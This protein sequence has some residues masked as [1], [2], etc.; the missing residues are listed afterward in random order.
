MS[1]PTKAWMNNYNALVDNYEKTASIN[2]DG[3]LIRIAAQQR[4]RYRS[5]D[6]SEQQVKLLSDIPGWQ[7][8]PGNF[9]SVTLANYRQWVR[10]NKGQHPPKGHDLRQW[11]DSQRER[12]RQ[13]DLAELRVRQFDDSEGGAGDHDGRPSMSTSCRARTCARA[14]WHP[15]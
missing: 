4:Y 10:D 6:L 15:P 2:D 8:S 1:H 3:Q 11:A 12:R 14:A 7:W 9:W 13:G 5:C